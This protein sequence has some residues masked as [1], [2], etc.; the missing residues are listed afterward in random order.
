M[1]LKKKDRRVVA[2]TR[3]LGRIEQGGAA[4]AKAP[5]TDAEQFRDTGLNNASSKSVGAQQV[6]VA[7]FR[8]VIGQIHSQTLDQ[9]NRSRDHLRVNLRASDLLCGSSAPSE[10]RYERVIVGQ[11]IEASFTATAHSAVADMYDAH[12]SW[13]YPNCTQCRS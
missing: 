2:T 1:E 12:P 6:E 10:F 4:L 3:G 7:R 8:R 13:R 9:A 11:P 5:R